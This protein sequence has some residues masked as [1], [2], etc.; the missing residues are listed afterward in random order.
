[1]SVQRK[2]KGFTI[3]EVVLVLAIAA[4]IL[5]MA[6]LAFPALLRNQKDTQRKSDLNRAITSVTNYQT[7]NRNALPGT[8]AAQWLAFE[9]SYLL[10]NGD[11]FMDPSGVN[12]SQTPTTPGYVFTLSAVG[13]VVPAWDQATT[14]NVIYFTTGAICGNGGTTVAAGSTKV[15][16]RM[17][18]EGGGTSCINN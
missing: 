18:L 8:T 17:A 12:T 13:A 10:I 9:N 14:Q 11:N 15:A 5:L 7:N 2:E 16:L 1:M 6:I 4:L 3:I